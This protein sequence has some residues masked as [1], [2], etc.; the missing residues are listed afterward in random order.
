M[1]KEMMRVDY[2]AIDKGIW[3][4]LW[5]TTCQLELHVVTLYQDMLKLEDFYIISGS[6]SID[7]HINTT[8]ERSSSFVQPYFPCNLTNQ[9]SLISQKDFIWDLNFWEVL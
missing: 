6:Y 9:I 4:F 1:V 3:L 7:S 8:W 2:N 5:P